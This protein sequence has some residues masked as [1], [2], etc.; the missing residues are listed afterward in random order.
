[1]H[2]FQAGGAS[3][4]TPTSAKATVGVAP[5]SKK[6]KPGPK[7]R[8]VSNCGSDTEAPLTKVGGGGGG[9]K[10]PPPVVKAEVVELDT[11]LET[12]DESC[13]GPPLVYFSQFANACK[14]DCQSCGDFR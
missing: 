10:T 7:S 11:T 8:K 6:A 4:T 2:V 14:F 9:V 3:E 1:M 5:V 12:G 13:G